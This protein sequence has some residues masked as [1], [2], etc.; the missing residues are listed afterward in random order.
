M[1]L[2]QLG[3]IMLKLGLPT[4][5]ESSFN[6][7]LDETLVGCLVGGLLSVV[8]E[9]SSMTSSLMVLHGSSISSSLW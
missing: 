6:T 1:T 8:F 9:S 7:H 2:S 5:E 4:T 3:V